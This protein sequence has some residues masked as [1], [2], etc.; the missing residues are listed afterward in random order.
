MRRSRFLQTTT[1]SVCCTSRRSTSAWVL[2][3]CRSKREGTSLPIHTKTKRTTSDFTDDTRSCPS[4][5]DANNPWNVAC[6][7]ATLNE[8]LSLFSAWRGQKFENFNGATDPS[9]L[10]HL[11]SGCPSGTEVGVAWLGTVCNQKSSGSAPSVV[12]GTA[13]STSGRTEWQ[14]V[15]HEIGHNFGAIV[16]CFSSHIS[17]M[18]EPVFPARLFNWLLPLRRLLP[19]Q[20]ANLRLDLALPYVARLVEQRTSLLT[21]HD[22]EHLLADEGQQPRHDVHQAA[23]SVGEDVLSANVR[24]RHHRAGRGLRPRRGRR[25]TVLRL[26]DM[27]VPR[28]RRVRPAL[29]PVLYDDVPVRARDAGLPA[30]EGQCVRHRRDMHGDVGAVPRRQDA[31]QRT[32][33]RRRRARVRQRPLHERHA[34]VPDRRCQPWPHERVPAKPAELPDRM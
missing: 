33:V 21:L 4:S 29:E 1:P 18:N 10:W 31:V 8:R 24:Q 30:V 25:L 11:M 27:Q 23:G 7:S 13:V 12:S 34:T 14:V 26:G 5:T 6:G 3:R 2:S 16:S 15:A 19:A 32:N 17:T 28:E 20:R 22:R 9:G